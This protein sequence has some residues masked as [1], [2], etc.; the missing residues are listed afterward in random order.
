[1]HGGEK[2]IKVVKMT[3]TLNFTGIEKQIAKFVKGLN[4]KSFDCPL[5]KQILCELTKPVTSIIAKRCP[6]NA[7]AHGADPGDA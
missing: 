3:R 2:T 5:A 6:Q 4:S 1:L 7:M